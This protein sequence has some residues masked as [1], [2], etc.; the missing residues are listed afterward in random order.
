M[1]TRRKPSA[2]S[3]GADDSGDDNRSGAGHE[4]DVQLAAGRVSLLKAIRSCAGKNERI[5]RKRIK[6]RTAAARNIG[7]V[8]RTAPAVAPSSSS[9]ERAR[10]AAAEATERARPDH[11][12][13]VPPAIEE[14]PAAI[15]ISAAVAKQAAAPA[16]SEPN[17]TA[18]QAQHAAK[19]AA[20]VSPGQA[21][22]TP[23]EIAPR[24]PAA[25]A[26]HDQR[27]RACSI[28][29]DK[30]A[31]SSAASDSRVASVECAAG[32][33]DRQRSPTIQIEVSGRKRPPAAKH[34]R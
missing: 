9:S 3:R 1:S 7:K 14:A 4:R 33:H 12:S 21:V 25:A 26:R 20:A 10:A 6:V 2:T 22:T 34:P 32:N 30:R 5:E 31:A 27:A 18:A 29:D 8:A 19:G 11:R 28:K 24:C 13:P 16:G 17:P 15:L 23:P